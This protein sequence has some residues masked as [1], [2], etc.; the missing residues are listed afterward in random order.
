MGKILRKYLKNLRNFYIVFQ[1]LKYIKI[2]S[3]IGLKVL[4]YNFKILVLFL[5][6]LAQFLS[7]QLKTLLKWNFFSFVGSEIN[8]FTDSRYTPL[9]FIIE[10]NFRSYT[11]GW[12]FKLVLNA[13]E[14]KMEGTMACNTISERTDFTPYKPD[15]REIALPGC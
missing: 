15:I 13:S 9:Q 7:T 6:I 4:K 14:R 2:S 5:N 1:I 3:V 12:F 8:S 11:L 10:G